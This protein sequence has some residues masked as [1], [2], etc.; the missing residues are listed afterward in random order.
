MHKNKSKQTIIERGNIIFETSRLRLIKN[1]L[2]AHNL[3]QRCIAQK[4]NITRSAISH[5][6]NGERCFRRNEVK[7]LYELLINTP[8]IKS[9]TSAIRYY[10]TVFLQDI[11]TQESKTLDQ[12]DNKT[13]PIRLE[14]YEQFATQ[15]R[16]IY[17]HQTNTEKNN[18]IADLEAIVAKYQ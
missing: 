1:A 3:T 5:K 4:L 6:L 12:T 14:L 17:I 11:Y 2:D 10:L 16:K 7:Q 18:I 8:I 15:L 13:D 9:D